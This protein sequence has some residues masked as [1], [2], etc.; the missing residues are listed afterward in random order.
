[1]IISDLIEE[2]IKLK[3]EHGDLNVT[4]WADHGEDVDDP[5]EQQLNR[6]VEIAG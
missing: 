4:V 3:D 6:V 5:E 2:L 1:M